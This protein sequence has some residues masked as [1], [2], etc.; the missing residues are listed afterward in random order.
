MSNDDQEL[1][2]G[3]TQSIAGP[4]QFSEPWKIQYSVHYP[5]NGI[6]KELQSVFP[7]LELW[8]QLNAEQEQETDKP[9]PTEIATKELKIIATFQ[10][11][12]A[13]L[14]DI[15]DE[16]E[17][18]RNRMF[19]N[20][21]KWSGL[22]MDNLEKTGKWAD[23]TDPMTGYPIRS[24]RGGMTFNE[25]EAYSQFFPKYQTLLCGACTIIIHPVWDS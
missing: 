24:D 12:A 25:V 15:S 4:I 16:T 5:L 23:T 8:K 9:E 20:F 11:S 17:V 13:D 18:E 14:V 7:N 21:V 3:G 6:I 19:D 1:L 22:V 10:Q 2:L